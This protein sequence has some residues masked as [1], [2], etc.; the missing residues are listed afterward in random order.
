MSYAAIKAGVVQV[1]RD[2]AGEVAPVATRRDSTGGVR[3]I[4]LIDDGVDG[5]ERK[6]AVEPRH[7]L[8]FVP[9]RQREHDAPA[10][11]AGLLD[12]L[13]GLNRGVER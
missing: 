6:K 9:G 11:G 4:G 8:S 2:G 5:C 10:V 3:L 13:A 7:D 12:R 1:V